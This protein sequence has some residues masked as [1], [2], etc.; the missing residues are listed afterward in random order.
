MQISAFQAILSGIYFWLAMG[1][2]GF[3]TAWHRPLFAGMIA[4][5]IMGD[6]TTGIRV[7]AMI[8]PMYF[9]FNASDNRYEGYAWDLCAL[10]FLGAVIHIQSGIDINQA[11]TVSIP[12]SISFSWIHVARRIILAYPAGMAQRAAKEGK[13]RAILFYGSWFCWLVRFFLYGLPITLAMMFG[14]KHIGNIIYD[15]PRWFYNSILSVGGILPALGIAKI[16]HTIGQ[17][18]FLPL[19]LFSYFLTQYVYLYGL[20]LTMG[21]L[22]VAFLYYLILDASENDVLNVNREVK[23]GSDE[24]E[25]VNKRLL[26][27]RDVSRIYIRWWWFAEQSNNATTFQ[28][29][30]FCCAFIPILKKLYGSETQ[31]YRDALSR[32]LLLFSTNG[33]WGAFIPGFVLAMEEH[34]AI[35]APIDTA[36]IIGIKTGLMQPLASIGS[37]IDWWVLFALFSIWGMRLSEKGSLLGPLLQ[38]VLTT[39]VLFFEGL[40]YCHLGYRFGQRGMLKIIQSKRLVQF[41]SFS[42]VLAIF[43][44]GGLSTTYV[45]VV[46]PLWFATNDP[47]VPLYVQSGILDKIALGILPLAFIFGAYRMFQKGYSMFRAGITLLLLGFLLNVIGIIGK[48]GLLF[49]AFVSPKI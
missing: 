1:D 44:L 38:F 27:N 2:L 42:T 41:I 17:P 6:I 46:T 35:G 30:A 14:I 29:L 15:S 26:T 37:S 10:T 8:Q 45:R 21:G 4:G 49:K 12:L 48:G 20:C 7:G 5:L 33:I 3:S 28:G 39:G 16:V 25:K 9:A 40:F 13:S 31:E 24:Q 11:V 36:S 47:K 23:E 34:R 18:K 19:F 22:F 43:M 32:H